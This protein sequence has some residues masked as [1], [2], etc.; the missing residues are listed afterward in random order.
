MLKNWLDRPREEAYVFNPAFIASLMCDF[1]LEYQKAKNNGC[2][3]TF[4]F[5]AP[6]LSLHRA[7]RTRLPNTTVTAMYE[8]VQNNEDVLIDLQRRSKALLPLLQEASAFGLHQEIVMFTNGHHL[9]TG[10]QKG[11]FVPSLLENV[12]TEMKEII[13][14]TRFLARWFA[15]S[16]SEAS[17][18]S[19]WSMR[20]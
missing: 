12:S 13:S 10:A 14:T 17:I 11:H 9:K 3:L 5:L 2:P 6:T 15:K 7:T 1:V 4:V 8:W 19:S 16:G 20:P 18:L